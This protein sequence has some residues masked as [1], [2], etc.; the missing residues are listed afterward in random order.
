MDMVVAYKRRGKGP[1]TESWN[2]FFSL[3]VKRDTIFL[4]FY[5]LFY[6]RRHHLCQADDFM[7]D[8]DDQA[9]ERTNRIG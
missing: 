9:R 5:V 7:A 8:D 1:G 4:F 3:G 2:G 6:C